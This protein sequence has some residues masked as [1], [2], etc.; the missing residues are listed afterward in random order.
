MERTGA[1]KF[2][3]QIQ[4]L[5]PECDADESR[6][7]HI[8]TMQC[9]CDEAKH[10]QNMHEIWIQINETW[11]ENFPEAAELTKKSSGICG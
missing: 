1:C 8:A 3:G 9:T 11:G 6:L 2:C 5:H 4:V 10:Y 7:E